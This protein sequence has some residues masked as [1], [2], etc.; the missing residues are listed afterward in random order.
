VRFGFL[1]T[2]AKDCFQDD[3]AGAGF[4]FSWVENGAAP[5]TTRIHI[6]AFCKKSIHSPGEKIPGGNSTLC[7]LKR[8]LMGPVFYI[9]ESIVNPN[10]QFRDHPPLNAASD[11]S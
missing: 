1:G 9:S 2:A 10:V 7:G 8:I 6:R 5:A 4:L 3:D 11:L